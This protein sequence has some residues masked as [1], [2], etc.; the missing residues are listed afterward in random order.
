[1]GKQNALRAVLFGGFEQRLVTGVAQI[2]LVGVGIGMRMLDL[3]V[4][5]EGPVDLCGGR[6]IGVGTGPMAVI[7][8]D[9]DRLRQPLCFNYSTFTHCVQPSQ[10]QKSG[11][12][13]S[14]TGQQHGAVSRP[15]AEASDSV[16]REVEHDT[17]ISASTLSGYPLLGF[18]RQPPNHPF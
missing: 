15:G 18:F 9:H 3:D 11:V 16:C 4:K 8:H 2:G 13:S 14:R 5:A 17:R 12:S 1:M 6:G 7:Y 10:G